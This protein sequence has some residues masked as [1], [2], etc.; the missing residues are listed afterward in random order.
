MLCQDTTSHRITFFDVFT[1]MRMGILMPL[2]MAFCKGLSFCVYVFSP[3]AHPVYM[4]IDLLQAYRYI[5]T[6]PSSA[7]D[8]NLTSEPTARRRDVATMLRLDGKVTGRSIAYVTTQVCQVLQMFNVSSL[9]IFYSSFSHLAARKS[10]RKIMLAFTSPHCII[11]SLTPSKIL[12]TTKPR[13][14]PRNSCNG[15]TGM[16]K[17]NTRGHL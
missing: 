1:R 3:C 9:T 4:T 2:R 12:K 5:F 17:S 7:S 15:G 11:S 16:F 6:S 13:R 10:G 14:A 8:E